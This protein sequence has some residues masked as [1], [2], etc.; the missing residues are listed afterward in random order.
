M[1][2]GRR[3][4]RRGV[5]QFTEVGADSIQDGVDGTESLVGIDQVD[6]DASAAS[7]GRDGFRSAEAGHWR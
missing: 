2:A 5:S 1:I 4:G 7:T 3:P 6:A